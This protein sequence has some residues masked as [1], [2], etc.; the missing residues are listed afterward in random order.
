MDRFLTIIIPTR[1]RKALLNE[2]VSSIRMA[3]QKT[4]IIIADNSDYLEQAATNFTDK[5]IKHVFT[6]GSLSIYENFDFGIKLCD[7]EYSLILAD[8][9]QPLFEFVHKALKIC[10][11]DKNISG[12]FGNVLPRQVERPLQRKSRFKS[13]KKEELF[14]IDKISSLGKTIPF[15]SLIGMIVKTSLLQDVNFKQFGHKS[16][17]NSFLMHIIAKN[18][19]RFLNK[20]MLI[21]NLHSHNDHLN[22][23]Q[24]DLCED[25]DQYRK[26][27]QNLED[28]GFCTTTDIDY[29]IFLSVMHRLRKY[30]KHWAI[31]LQYCFKFCSFIRLISFISS[32]IYYRI[33][34]FI[35]Y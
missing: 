14:P 6:G 16:A 30:K 20:P 23:D 27:L 33:R 35:Q 7:T 22:Y 12:V 32:M 34:R 26:N 1:N 11:E 24:I 3:S 17:D 10:S 9:D 29:L 5:E 13:Q 4:E 28:L 18:D 2:L 19:I 31:L 15:P 21:Q 8:D 25:L